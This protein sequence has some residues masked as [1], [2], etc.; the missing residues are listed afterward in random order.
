M[1]KKAS[2]PTEALQTPQ[3]LS[4]APRAGPLAAPLRGSGLRLN[5][6]LLVALEKK[7]LARVGD[8]LFPLAPADDVTIR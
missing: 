7:G 1:S 2:P 5:P 3:P 4:I 8:I 6:R